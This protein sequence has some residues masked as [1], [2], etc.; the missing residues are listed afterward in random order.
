MLAI[1]TLHTA[2]SD[3]EPKRVYVLYVTS[4]Y[5]MEYAQKQVENE[6]LIN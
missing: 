3:S 1:A 6:W 4:A 5:D 2:L